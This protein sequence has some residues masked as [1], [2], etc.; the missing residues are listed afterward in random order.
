MDKNNILYIYILII[1]VILVIISL[2]DY[3][4]DKLKISIAITRL[5]CA[6]LI[7]IIAIQITNYNVYIGNTIFIIIIG[8][9]LLFLKNKI[10]K[11]NKIN[12]KSNL[13]K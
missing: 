12:I 3:Y 2:I 9:L 4:N 6:L 7:S 11:F 1:I 5:L 10:S 13:D 8:L